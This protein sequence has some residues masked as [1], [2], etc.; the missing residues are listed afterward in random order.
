M[1]KVTDRTLTSKNVKDLLTDILEKDQS[2]NELIEENN[3]SNITDNSI[4]KEIIQEIL[5]NNEESIKDY[6]SGHDRALKYLM[7]QVMKKTK[8]SADPLLANNLL[9]EELESRK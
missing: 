4:L 7:G 3:I 8:G 9:K 2:I 5:D 6:I 1:E